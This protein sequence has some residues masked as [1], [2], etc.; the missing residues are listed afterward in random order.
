MSVIENI[1]Y[2]MVPNCPNKGQAPCD[3]V[4]VCVEYDK[5]GEVV[6]K[7]RHLLKISR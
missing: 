7:D 2:T 4:H 6:E 3:F 5:Y 1:L